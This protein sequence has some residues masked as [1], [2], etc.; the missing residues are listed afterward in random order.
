MKRT[1]VN[2][3]S[4]GDTGRSGGA[5]F[6]LRPLEPEIGEVNDC[7]AE[8]NAEGLEEFEESVEDEEE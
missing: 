6:F 4:S 8:G 3:S 7:E 2:S 1:G 5:P